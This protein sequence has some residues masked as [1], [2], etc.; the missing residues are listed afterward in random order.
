MVQLWPCLNVIRHCRRSKSLLSFMIVGCLFPLF[1]TC[2][3]LDPSVSIQQINNRPIT[4]L[5]ES[6][7]QLFVYVLTV[8][9]SCLP[10]KIST[11]LAQRPLPDSIN[12]VNLGKAFPRAA[13]ECWGVS[14]FIIFGLVC[15]LIPINN[16]FFYYLH[17][18]HYLQM[19]FRYHSLCQ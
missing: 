8:N 14:A 7:V 11:F 9:N 5:A 1:S 6:R 12:K 4:A 2:I 13:F 17:V 15:S 10:R 16:I 18:S 3:V 19:H